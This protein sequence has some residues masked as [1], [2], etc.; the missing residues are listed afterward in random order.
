MAKIM[1]HLASLFCHRRPPPELNALS[2]AVLVDE[3]GCRGFVHSSL[4]LKE[5]ALNIK[6]LGR[7]AES[8][9]LQKFVHL[10]VS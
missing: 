6:F 8:N 3:G 5:S 1:Q 2:V 9:V 7:G 10:T 4:C